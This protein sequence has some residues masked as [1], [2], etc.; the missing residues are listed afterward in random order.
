M[1]CASDHV[2]LH[3][4]LSLMLVTE[5]DALVAGTSSSPGLEHDRKEG[6]AKRQK[7]AARTSL[8]S[9]VTSLARGPRHSRAPAVF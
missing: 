5:Q 1:A 6:R 2:P 9:S 4:G 8:A 7:N 3:L